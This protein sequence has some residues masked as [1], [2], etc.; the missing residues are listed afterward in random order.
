M[1][2][3]FYKKRRGGGGGAEN[4]TQKMEAASEK[5]VLTQTQVV[6]FR[7]NLV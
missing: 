2:V 5:H 3:E 6:G 1:E 7:N 4:H